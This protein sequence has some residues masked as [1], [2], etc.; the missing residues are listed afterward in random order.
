MIDPYQVTDADG[1]FPSGDAFMVYPYKDT[2][3]ESLRAVVFHEG[4]QDMRA[5]QLLE[6]LTSKEEVVKIMEEAFGCELKF[7]QYPKNANALIAMR[8]K[9]NRLLAEL[10]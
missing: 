1:A 2:V 7:K 10:A 3:I 9:I 5:L 4:L 6:S 8:E